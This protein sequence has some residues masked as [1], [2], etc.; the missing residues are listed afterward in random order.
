MFEELIGE[1]LPDLA[2]QIPDVSWLAS[3]S[4]TWFLT[5]FL[6]VLPFRS[7]LCV[8]DCFFCHGIRAVFQISLAVLEANAAE[9][10]TC[11]DDGQA[12]MILNR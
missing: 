11:T 7:A 6:S 8:L 3:V 10:S 5:L 2:E 4:L 1:R 12:L 9:L